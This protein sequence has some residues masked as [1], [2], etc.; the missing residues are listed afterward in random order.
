MNSWAPTSGPEMSRRRS[1]RV[2]LHVPIT[3]TSE[4]A[5]TG[6]SEPTS[7]LVVNAHG[8]LIT[9]Q[10]KVTAGQTLTISSGASEKRSCRVVY[11]GPTLQGR[12]QYGIEFAE[13]APNFWHITFPPED[14]AGAVDLAEPKKK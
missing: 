5:K 2:L 9:L 12:T 3:V 4:D 8:A 13:A 1:H 7:T 11:V 10:A 6:F 14:W